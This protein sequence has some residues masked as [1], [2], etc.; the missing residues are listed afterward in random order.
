MECCSR[1]SRNQPSRL[2]N[3]FFELSSL[4]SCF[5]CYYRIYKWSVESRPVIVAFGHSSTTKI[6]DRLELGGKV[7]QLN[8]QKRKTG[9]LLDE[10]DAHLNYD[11]AERYFFP[12]NS[13]SLPLRFFSRLPNIQGIACAKTGFSCGPLVADGIFHRCLF[14]VC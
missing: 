13:I 6:L 1:N 10:N 7:T 9:Y 2:F 8:P 4:F 3:S 12:P 5:V 11:G 14:D